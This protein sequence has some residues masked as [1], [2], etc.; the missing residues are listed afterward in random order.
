VF[1]LAAAIMFLIAAIK[2]GHTDSAQF[3]LYLGL[4]LW[5][6]HFAFEPFV[7]RYYPY[8]RTGRTRGTTVP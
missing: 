2:Q 5:A 1:A 7:A 3:W 4:M 6:L 8:N